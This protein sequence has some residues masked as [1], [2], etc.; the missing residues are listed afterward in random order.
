[1]EYKTYVRQ[2][3]CSE[4]RLLEHIYNKTCDL[5]IRLVKIN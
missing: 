1:M 5:N 2:Q 4:I 3:E